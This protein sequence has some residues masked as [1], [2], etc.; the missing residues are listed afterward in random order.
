ME[1]ANGNQ[2]F[3]TTPHLEKKQFEKEKI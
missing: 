2:A 1:H 3:K